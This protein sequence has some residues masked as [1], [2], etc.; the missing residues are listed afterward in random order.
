MIT[1]KSDSEN[2]EEVN[3]WLGDAINVEGV[4]DD[5]EKPTRLYYIS[6]LDQYDKFIENT[7]PMEAHLKSLKIAFGGYKNAFGLIIMLQEEH[8]MSYIIERENII[9]FTVEKKQPVNVIKHNFFK[10]MKKGMGGGGALGVLVTAAIGHVGDKMSTP[11]IK[12]VPGTI[13]KL[14]HL[15]NGKSKTIVLVSEKEHEFLLEAFL[16][17]YYVKELLPEDLKKDGCYIATVAYQN[18]N[19][20]EVIAFRKYRDN[21]LSKNSVGRTFIWLYYK[22]SPSIANWLKGKKHIN[23][24][25]KSILDRIYKHIK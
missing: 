22:I 23:T 7:T 12:S 8:F 9:G 6:G 10:T 14:Q 15:E 4:E 16:K 21:D 20:P 18:K 17:R 11:K 13:Y 1:I 3:N 2:L 24:V 25:I 5:Y 19:A